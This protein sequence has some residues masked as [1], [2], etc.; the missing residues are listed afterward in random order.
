MPRTNPEAVERQ[1]DQAEMREIRKKG[2]RM[3][4]VHSQGANVKA[5]QERNLHG[6]QFELLRSRWGN[7]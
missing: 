1:R 4:V 5:A 7:A 3:P 6:A 2:C